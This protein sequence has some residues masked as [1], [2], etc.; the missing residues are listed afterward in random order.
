MHTWH[1]LCSISR[2]GRSNCPYLVIPKEAP[3]DYFLFNLILTLFGAVGTLAQWRKRQRVRERINT[4]VE[5]IGA[6]GEV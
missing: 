2:Y 5:A 6:R 1:I 3:M 4:R